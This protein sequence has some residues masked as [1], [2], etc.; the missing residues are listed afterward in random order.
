MRAIVIYGVRSC[1]NLVSCVRS[2][3]NSVYGAWRGRMF[4]VIVLKMSEYLMESSNFNVQHVNVNVQS[5][6]HFY[7]FLMNKMESCSQ[8]FNKHPRL[9]I[10]RSK[11]HVPSSKF[12]IMSNIA[13]GPLVATCRFDYLTIFPKTT[14]RFWKTTK[15]D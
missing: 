8:V 2:F 1:E 5:Q 6:C 4:D 7:I 3:E 14:S 10:P 11:F 13:P 12:P 9:S 15:N